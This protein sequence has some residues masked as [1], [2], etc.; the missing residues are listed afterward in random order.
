MLE[1][2][3]HHLFCLT[4]GCLRRF[5]SVLPRLTKSLCPITDGQ[6][7]ITENDKLK[8]SDTVY[9]EVLQSFKNVKG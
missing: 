4:A 9:R 2:I 3:A 1:F 8:P 7:Q 5:P 6:G